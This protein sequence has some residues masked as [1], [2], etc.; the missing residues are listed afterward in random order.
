MPTQ[1]TNHLWPSCD[2]A[3]FA[4]NFGQARP[5][6]HNDRDV[7]IKYLRLPEQTREVVEKSVYKE[8][9]T[10]KRLKH[11]N[12]VAFI[13]VTRNPLQ[14][15]SDWMPNGTLR[16]YV[17]NNP[18]A[19]RVGL[20]L[21]V[22]EGLD[23]LHAN[24]TT[25]GDLKGPN[26]LVDYTG[27]ACLA[28]FGFASVVRGLTSIPVT[29]VQGYTARWAAPEV[30]GNGDK[31]TREADVF[32]F[33]MVVV[34]V[35][36]G[37]C[38]FSEFTA[39]FTISK[40]MDGER[41]DRP[42]EPGLT[43]SVW[44]I[45]RTCWSQDPGHRPTMPQ[46]V[47]IFRECYMTYAEDLQLSSL[48]RPQPVK[49]AVS[50]KD[51]DCAMMP[52]GFPSDYRRI[53][54]LSWELTNRKEGLKGERYIELLQL[55]TLWHT[56]P[57]SYELPGVVKQGDRALHASMMTEIWEGMCG[58][59]V[60]ALKVLRL[61]KGKVNSDAEAHKDLGLP[62]HYPDMAKQRFCAAAVMMKQ[63]EH[64]N[65]LP[66][67][68]VSTTA[69]S[70]SLVFPCYQNGNID[71][72]LEK[73]PDVDRYDLILGAATGLRFLHSNGKFHGAFR[74]DH[75]LI[76]DNGNARLEIAIPDMPNV[77]ISPRSLDLASRSQYPVLGLEDFPYGV[78]ETKSMN[79]DVYELAIV[80]YEV[81]TGIHTYWE[82]GDHDQEF[83]VMPVRPPGAFDDLFWG[84]LAKCWRRRPMERPHMYEVYG[85][86]KSRPK[87][88]RAP[89]GRFEGPES[90]NE[91]ELHIHGIKFRNGRPPSQEFYVK[92]KYGEKGYT[93][94][95]T[96]FQ[97]DWGE[98]TWDSPQN[99][100]IKHTGRSAVLVEV[101]LVMVVRS[102]L[103]KSEKVYAIGI[104][105]FLPNQHIIVYLTDERM[106]LAKVLILV[107]AT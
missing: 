26:I 105:S 2:P 20:L 94:S 6:S 59:K 27:R 100:V 24:H 64:A 46:V 15:I 14:I 49:R 36:T 33:G 42:Q 9:I 75:I 57:T 89:W 83:P 23:Y 81:L 12:F 93:T 67:Y 103:R 55:C 73:N 74:P 41:P 43:D 30:L 50:A 18:G 99:L 52:L 22:A 104:S 61:H 95:L 69:S 56:V 17:N 16:E 19:N 34:E 98:Y 11:P 58:G 90:R 44:D 8:A 80:I 32:S 5:S 86:V 65:I 84:L 21:D 1:T 40:I 72:Y 35:F 66:F 68:G 10:W 79:G 107:T 62:E 106:V 76:D 45:T 29:E 7:C 51:V 88:K 13:G 91:Y 70:F 63:I 82:G 85:T 38:P 25:H 48:S 71:Q 54:E 92:F 47:G 3:I 53:N 102:G 28:D 31:N 60:V 101:S 4:Y 96:I 37:T 78:P 77:A 87:V 39:N 97:N